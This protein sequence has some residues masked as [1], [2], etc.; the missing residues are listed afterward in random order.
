MNALN[1]RSGYNQ[2]VVPEQKESPQL[3]YETT[4]RPRG[5]SSFGRVVMGA[6]AVVF[7]AWGWEVWRELTRGSYDLSSLLYPSVL[8]SISGFIVC[9]LAVI[10]VIGGR[11]NR[12]S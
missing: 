4:R 1:A 7:L 8:F 12:S 2:D 6:F 9:I 5:L 10:G 3:D 11:G